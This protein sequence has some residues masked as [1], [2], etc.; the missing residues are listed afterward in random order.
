[1]AFK[2][3]GSPMHRNYGI[4]TPNKKADKE[5]K[6]LDDKT[7]PPKTPKMTVTTEQKRPPNAPRSMRTIGLDGVRSSTTREGKKRY[8]LDVNPLP[9]EEGWRDPQLQA[10][11]AG[12]GKPKTRK[13]K[14]KDRRAGK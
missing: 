1:M 5:T 11:G 12:I 8:D 2:M 10:P 7:N 13:E 3:K 6:Y 4:G 9:N 14:R